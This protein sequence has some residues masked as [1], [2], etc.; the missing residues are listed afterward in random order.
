MLRAL[1]LGKEPW[2]SSGLIRAPLG[3]GPHLACFFGAL[4]R[5]KLLGHFLGGRMGSGQIAI[6]VV[7][8]VAQPRFPKASLGTHVVPSA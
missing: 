7:W 2:G 6:H 1:G 4:R 3:D 8:H 5:S